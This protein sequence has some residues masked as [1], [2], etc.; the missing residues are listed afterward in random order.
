MKKIF[1]FCA[2]VL[3]IC[4]ASV[5]FFVLPGSEIH[6]NEMTDDYCE[7]EDIAIP[8]G[9]S[10]TVVPNTLSRYGATLRFSNNTDYRYTYGLNEPMF[11]YTKDDN[12]NWVNVPFARDFG[13][14]P[15]ARYL[16]PGR[17]IIIEKNFE[18]FFGQLPDGKYKLTK[19]VHRGRPPR[20]EIVSAEFVIRAQCKT[21]SNTP[22][23]RFSFL[24]KI[25]RT[26]NRASVTRTSRGK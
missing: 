18:G 19:S 25:C 26:P 5:I 1:L 3:I 12:D 9:L 16:D 23:A 2:F 4:V 20:N 13:W 17:Y 21:A 8:D 11:L 24:P 15:I 22:P 6:E 7:G 10:L 14:N